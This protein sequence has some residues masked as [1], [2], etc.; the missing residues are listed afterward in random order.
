MTPFKDAGN[1]IAAL[2]SEIGVRPAD[3]T[4]LRLAGEAFA[5]LPHLAG[6]LDRLLEFSF[7]TSGR[8][9]SQKLRYVIDVTALSAENSGDL[10]TTGISLLGDI[11][12]DARRTPTYRRLDDVYDEA[13]K[14]LLY[15]IGAEHAPHGAISSFKTYWRFQSPLEELRLLVTGH[16][17]D[18]LEELVGAAQ[19]FWPGWKSARLVGIDY[20]ASGGNRFKAYLPQKSFVEPLSLV[21]FCEF[22]LRLGWQVNLEVFAR[23][24]Y[25]VLGCQ[26]EVQPTAYSLG[27]A[28]GERPSIKLEIAVKAYFDNARRALDAVLRL[29]E[30]LGLDPS[31]VQTGVA[32]LEKHSPLAR[33]PITE[34]LCLDFYPQGS[35]RVIVY[36]GL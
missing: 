28:I 23:L 17:E 26:M 15:G 22:L 11:P 4:L 3:I 32:A 2:S 7:S 5:G 8:S 18:S 21:A 27:F 20:L 34:V 10:I 19:A 13:G 1:W 36:C 12:E 9:S 16:N 31:P 14:P 24:S 33:P 30:S 25:F 35:N 6:S 29:A